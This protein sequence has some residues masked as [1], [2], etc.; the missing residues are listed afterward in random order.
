MHVGPAPHERVA[1]RHHALYAAR[2]VR[3]PPDGS[4]SLLLS[5]WARYSAAAASRPVYLTAR[6]PPHL[7][8]DAPRRSGGG[9]PRARTG[10]R[11][12]RGAARVGPDAIVRVD[13]ASG[14]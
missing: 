2:E 13:L 11:A 1:A 4:G 10:T 8:R 3:W 12:G 9:R 14:E 5:A 7:L 6:R